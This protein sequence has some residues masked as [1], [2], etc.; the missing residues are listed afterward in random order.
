MRTFLKVLLVI[1]LIL[2]ALIV[3]GFVYGVSKRGL[4][5]QEYVSYPVPEI[6]VVLPRDHAAHPDFKVEWWYYTGHLA[7]EDG[8]RYGFELTFFRYRTVNVWAGWLPLWWLMYPHGTMAHFAIT[9][10]EGGR[11]YSMDAVQKNSSDNVGAETETYHVWLR[12]WYVRG[13]GGE[14]ILHAGSEDLGL[15]LAVR[16]AKPVVL[17]GRE[18]YHWK[19][20]DG[21]PSYYISYTRMEVAGSIRLDGKEMPVGGQAWMDHEYTSFPQKKDA[22]GWDWFAIQLENNFDVML[23]QMRRRDGSACADS[24]GAVVG[25]YGAA[26]AIT[27]PAFQIRPTGTWTSPHTGARYPSG[28]QVN[29]PEIPAELK[30]TPL[31]VDQEMVME[32]SNIVYWEGTCEV[33][34]TWSGEPVQGRAYVE[35]SGYIRAITERL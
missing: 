34:G 21:V 7:G 11:L 28:W 13:S 24:T 15:D 23:Y 5:Q 14:H 30:V 3:L 31:V 16:P 18:G 6:P 19:G 17:H 4:H 22:Q 12:D 20:V 27:M 29:L 32:K 1:I 35:L 26:A 8:R 33:S 10:V 9:D 25:P 2:A